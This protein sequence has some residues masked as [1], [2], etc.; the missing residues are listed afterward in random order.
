MVRAGVV[1]G[2][3]ADLAVPV[4]LDDLPQQVRPARC[5]PWLTSLHLLTGDTWAPSICTLIQSATTRID[6]AAYAC[7]T[8]WPTLAT[9]RYNVYEHLLAAPARGLACTIVLAEHKRTAATARF[10]A[11]AAR[12]LAAAGWRVRRA[13]RGRLLHAKIF[14]FDRRIV[15]LG[16]HNIAHAASA[17]NLDLSACLGGEQTAAQFARWFDAVLARSV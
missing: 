8:R 1:A 15:V 7:S 10:N 16:S 12:A 14:L 5:A 2:Q 17:S 11:H 13:P 3:S 6:I 4:I 9:D